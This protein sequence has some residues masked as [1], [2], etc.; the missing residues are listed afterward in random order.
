[1]LGF[2]LAP[3]PTGNLLTGGRGAASKFATENGLSRGSEVLDNAD[4][5]QRGGGT[6]GTKGG[7][8]LH[9]ELVEATFGTAQG[10]R[11]V[12]R[13][14]D[15][16]DHLDGYQDP[17]DRRTQDEHAGDASRQLAPSQVGN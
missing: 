5:A 4:R 3:V 7:D 8:V 12:E 17:V 15:R 2:A 13:E 16:A 10:D 9:A 6:G 11:T 1:M 14:L